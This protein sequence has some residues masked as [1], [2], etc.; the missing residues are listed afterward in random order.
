MKDTPKFRQ[1]QNVALNLSRSLLVTSHALFRGRRR[2]R[3]IRSGLY[4]FIVTTATVAM[5]RLLV[6]HD[7]R[8]CTRL[9][10]DLWDFRKQLWFG[11]SPSMAIATDSSD[12]I[13][14]FLKQRCR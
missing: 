10:L 8:L 6:S 5:K 9:K 13:R 4:N 12:R 14:I 3:Q 1:H 11:I 2:R 7:R